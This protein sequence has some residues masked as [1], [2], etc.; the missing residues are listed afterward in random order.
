MAA[1]AGSNGPAVDNAVP[2]VGDVGTAAIVA[3]PGICHNFR[4]AGVCPRGENCKFSHD[5]A[6]NMAV[7]PKAKVKA[8]A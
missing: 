8:K 3:V 5:P 4:D 2:I 7:K 6:N 1:T